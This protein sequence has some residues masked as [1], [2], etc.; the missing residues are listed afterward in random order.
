MEARLLQN[1]PTPSTGDYPV[2]GSSHQEA[3]DAHRLRN[4]DPRLARLRRARSELNDNNQ[5][6]RGRNLPQS[7]H[8]AAPSP[9]GRGSPVQPPRLPRGSTH[10][11]STRL[12]PVLLHRRPALSPA[13][14]GSPR[15][16]SPGRKKFQNP[17]TDS[18]TDRMPTRHSRRA[19]RPVSP[20]L[21]TVD[22]PTADVSQDELAREGAR[23]HGDTHE[24]TI[25]SN[26]RH[27]LRMPLPS[28]SSSTLS[29]GQDAS[30][31]NS[32]HP[33]SATTG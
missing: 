1:E 9:G 12:E 10:G 11:V 29:G 25:S 7:I 17:V 30:E 32:Q 15:R 18:G 27:M 4:R 26:G 24:G 22:V 28:T 19:V 16:V 20:P 21:P 31:S 8:A 6:D 33:N 23:R 5:P 14:N 2:S 13:R 3:G